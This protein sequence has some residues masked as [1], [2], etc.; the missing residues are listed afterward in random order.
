MYDF[1]EE[2]VATDTIGTLISLK[3]RIKSQIIKPQHWET[4][5]FLYKEVQLINSRIEQLTQAQ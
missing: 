3:E 4:R 1:L 2:I 5:M